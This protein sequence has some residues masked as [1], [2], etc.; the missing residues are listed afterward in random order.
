MTLG[1]VQRAM[2]LLEA[3]IEGLEESKNHAT[4]RSGDDGSAFTDE[5]T[6][7]IK[8]LFDERK[9]Q[10]SPPNATDSLFIRAADCASGKPYS[11]NIAIVEKYMKDNPERWQYAMASA[12]WIAIFRTCEQK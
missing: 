11:Q 7:R 10:G 2:R 9:D 6:E 3:R 1:Y 4:D 5:Q 8:A 12:I